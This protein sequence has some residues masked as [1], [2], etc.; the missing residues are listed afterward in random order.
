MYLAGE[1]ISLHFSTYNWLT[2]S[3]ESASV[4]VK[5][6]RLESEVQRLQYEQMCD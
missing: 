5:L 3:H 2:D 4:N 6:Y 1:C